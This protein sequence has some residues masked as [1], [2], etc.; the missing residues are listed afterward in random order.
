MTLDNLQNITDEYVKSTNDTL[1]PILLW[2][3][4]VTQLFRE[5]KEFDENKTNILVADIDYMKDVA[6]LLAS[7]DERLI[8][9]LFKNLRSLHR[10]FFKQIEVNYKIYVTVLWQCLSHQL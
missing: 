5:F 10:I 6:V 2:K 8:G 3:P 1:I 7:T 9:T 4:F